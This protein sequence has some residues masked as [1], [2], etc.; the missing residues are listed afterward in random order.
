ML[1]VT[2]LWGRPTALLASARLFLSL[3]IMPNARSDSSR[4]CRCLEVKELYGL[5]CMGTLVFVLGTIITPGN[6]RVNGRYLL[7]Q[8][9]YL[10]GM[11]S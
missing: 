3:R 6:R 11:T 2:V 5:L 1:L 9:H 8:G 10:N 7:L 4:L